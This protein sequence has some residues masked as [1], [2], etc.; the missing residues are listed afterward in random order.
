MQERGMKEGWMRGEGMWG[1][2]IRE[3]GMRDEEKWNEEGS[4]QKRRD[5][6]RRKKRCGK[7]D[8]EMEEDT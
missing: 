5:E 4:D 6:R 3:R 7:M 8:K 2:R 1:V